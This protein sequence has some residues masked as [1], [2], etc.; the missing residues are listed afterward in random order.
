M[1]IVFVNQSVFDRVW[2][3]FGEAEEETANEAEG[4][5]DVSL[6]ADDDNLNLRV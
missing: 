3:K 6:K 1:I 5:V 2:S 4:L